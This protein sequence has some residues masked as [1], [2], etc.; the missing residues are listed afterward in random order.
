[1]S[2]PAP[3]DE[4]LVCTAVEAA[5]SPGSSGPVTWTVVPA[6]Q[7]RL[8]P[9]QPIDWFA[10]EADPRATPVK[11]NP[12]RQV[13]RVRCGDALLYTKVFAAAGWADRLSSLL[14]GPAAV[15][16][17]RVGR[18]AEGAKLPCVRFVACG[19]RRSGWMATDSVLITE[20]ADGTVSLP[21]AWAEAVRMDAQASGARVSRALADAVARLLADAH[22][23]RFLHRDGH[24]RN[25][26]VRGLGQSSPEVLYVDL[27]GAAVGA[28]L[29]DERAAEGLAQLDQ[30]FCRHAWRS[31]RLR[32]LRRYLAR[33]F[34]DETVSPD[35]V[36]RWAAAVERARCRQATRLHVQRDR[37]IR[38]QG[39]YF[40]TFR[41]G[42]WR[43]TVTTRFRNREEFPQPVH[44]D[45]T[46]EEARRWLE[47]LLPQIERSEPMP[48]DAMVQR[49]G[50][51]GKRP[52][53]GWPWRRAPA[54]RLFA[55]GH[56]LRHRNVA[57]V[58]PLAVLRRRVGLRGLESVLIMERRPGA[59]ALD[60]LLDGSCPEPERWQDVQCRQTI[61]LS[62]GRLLA[63]IST[64]GVI[65][66][67]PE[68]SQVWIDW[69]PPRGEPRVLI[70]RFEGI[71]FDHRAAAGRAQESVVALIRHLE[72]WASFE[73]ADAVVVRQA[74]WRRLGHLGSGTRRQLRQSAPV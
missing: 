55:V 35:V 27:Y 60:G 39:R 68:A 51:N 28:P 46:I 8:Q 36:R 67:A 52:G 6:W 34:G 74:F 44:P 45:R 47:G 1:M 56:G 14:R 50:M 22:T 18:Y 7:K 63:E 58:W 54:E 17:W 13:W 73:P 38:R 70:G 16:E 23:A 9:A 53:S 19:V 2:E 65:W 64:S 32:F 25:I 29:S 42:G 21:D 40:A 69:T 49:F 33:R 61:L 5:G 4:Q 26:L 48:D 30:W 24:P 72:S 12:N 3:I 15:R 11:A 10:L 71:R 57:C 31:A 66:A 62:L 37:R 59:V 20:A 43:A 41:L